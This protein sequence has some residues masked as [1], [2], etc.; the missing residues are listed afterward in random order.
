MP[1]A[2]LQARWHCKV[3]ADLAD[4]LVWDDTV[5]ISMESLLYVPGN[6]AL[7]STSLIKWNIVEKKNAHRQS[8]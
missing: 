1:R 6:G 3:W 8:M 4:W 2:L 5:R 7:T